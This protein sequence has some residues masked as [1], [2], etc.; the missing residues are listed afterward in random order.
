MAS[1]TA[2]FAT[3][4]AA[5]V[6]GHSVDHRPIELV[7]VPGPGPR[8]LVVGCIHG[9]ECAGL[10][11]VRALRRAHPRED[12]WL[13]PTL[14]PDGLADGTREN[15][16]GVDL[17]RDFPSGS[18]PWSQPESRVARAIVANVRPSFTIWFHQHLDLVW[19]YGRSSAAGRRYAQL[20]GLRYY[21]HRWLSGTATNWQSH[22]AAGGASITVELPAGR[23]D[24]RALARQVRAV[25][26]LAFAA[27]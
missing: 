8:V 9:N 18:H 25:L 15:A 12:L 19:A 6:V 23:L 2:M 26:R 21:H 20:S 27:P 10:A 24:R 16:N 17:N 1:I 14:N 7:H 13:V 22:R 11:V 5:V 3:L 4:A